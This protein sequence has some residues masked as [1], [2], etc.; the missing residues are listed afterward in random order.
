MVQATRAPLPLPA[1]A[2]ARGSTAPSRDAAVGGPGS[3]RPRGLTAL[4]PNSQTLGDW[5]APPGS[6][7]HRW[8]S[9]PGG[10]GSSLGPRPAPL[11]VV[12][13]VGPRGRIGAR[14][15]SE[16]GSGPKGGTHRTA[17]LGPLPRR[18][19]AVLASLFLRAERTGIVLPGPGRALETKAVGAPGQRKAG[20]TPLARKKQTTHSALGLCG[21]FES[22]G[23]TPQLARASSLREDPREPRR[24][25]LTEKS[26]PSL[27]HLRA[28]CCQSC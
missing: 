2:S 13:H 15:R 16:D 22:P 12:L 26:S 14:P 28:S 20:A 1:L 17:R 23:A 27:E 24:W 18:G 5:P 10:P 3:T 4:A 9:L 21:F 11:R 6:G 25:G 19:P 7:R 8:R